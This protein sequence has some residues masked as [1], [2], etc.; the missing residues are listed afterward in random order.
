MS[1]QR[2]DGGAR[3]KPRVCFLNIIP[4]K[5]TLLTLLLAFGGLASMAQLRPV[6]KKSSVKFTVK[7][8]GFDVDGT[9]SG[10]QG[11]IAFDPQSPT[12]GSID[13]TI[14]ANTVNTDNNMRDGHLKDG[15][16][17]DTKNYPNIRFVST[18]ITAAK[19]GYLITG[20]LT[21]KGKTKEITFPFAATNNAEGITFTGS[22]KINRKDFG[23]GG[24][25]IISN[26]LEVKLN[27][28]AVKA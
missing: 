3:R 16:Y 2:A 25:S 14:D 22:F 20:K 9:F 18:K 8:M 28:V 10:L 17:F 4:M 23:V 7:N 1:W 5:I 11:L 6:D 27:V 19:G 12:T 13:V 15:D 24:T 21:I 26:E